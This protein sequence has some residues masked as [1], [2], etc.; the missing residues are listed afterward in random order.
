MPGRF[1]YVKFDD[2]HAGLQA[3][4]RQVFEAIEAKIVTEL[5]DNRARSIALT[6]LEESYM[7][8]GKAIRDNQ[9]ALGIVTTG[10]KSAPAIAEVAS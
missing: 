3:Q 7:W 8:V 10:P 6:K 5:P 9:K 4:M 2:Y 1:D